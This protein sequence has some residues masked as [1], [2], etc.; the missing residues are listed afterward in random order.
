MDGILNINKPTG[1]TSHD[2]VA[3]VRRLL[4]QRR[5]GHAGT[6]DPA[7]S[8]VL[9]ICIGQAT[10]VAE[11]LSESGKAYRA[12]ITFGITTDTYDA[13]GAVTRTASTT[14]LSR[15][16]LESLLPS[17]KGEQMQVP[18]RYS[19]IKQQGQPA[20]K[21]ARAGEALELA[22]RPI[23]ISRLEI[24]EWMPPSLILDIEC[25]KGTYIRSLAH[26]LGERSGYGAHLSALVRTRSGPFHLAG[27]ITLEQLEEA[28]ARNDVREYL[29]PADAALEGYPGIRL[30]EETAAR[31]RHG[32][33]FGGDDDETSRG[34][35]RLARVYDS[36]GRFLAIAAWDGAR[37]VW[38]PV[39]VFGE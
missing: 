28:V 14:T 20:Y 31:V 39:K 35:N 29:Y 3:R 6:L 21:R 5:V 1:M 34:G 36:D 16:Y 17:L 32:N 9:P 33:A 15:A 26:D 19:A 18:P 27:S 11:Y 25:S 12:T 2:M 4:D 10:R 13:E 22:A 37:K 30:D 23:T 7:A 38:Q 24:I 8:G